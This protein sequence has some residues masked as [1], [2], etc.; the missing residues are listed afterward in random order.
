MRDA[1]IERL[2]L[3]DKP[4]FNFDNVSPILYWIRYRICFERKS[5]LSQTVLWT[6]GQ[7]IVQGSYNFEKKDPKTLFSFVRP[8]RTF[9]YLYI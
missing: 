2:D 4:L 7:K 5:W 8:L 1:S 9:V 3:A 6:G